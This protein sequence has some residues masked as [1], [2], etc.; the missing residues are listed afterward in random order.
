MSSEQHMFPSCMWRPKFPFH[1]FCH[2]S[3]SNATRTQSN[4]DML[5]CRCEM[6]CILIHV[7]VSCCIRSSVGR[8]WQCLSLQ[9]SGKLWW[10]LW[11]QLHCMQGAQ[12]GDYGR[13]SPDNVSDPDMAHE[14]VQNNVF[15]FCSLCK[16]NSEAAAG[17]VDVQ[18]TEIWTATA[19][20][21]EAPVTECRQC[22]KILSLVSRSQCYALY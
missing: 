4:R 19:N 9:V 22:C 2:V 10:I 7:F 13:Q 8:W 16:S 14:L 21:A 11:V 1:H 3:S 17:Y 18:V 12:T 5:K 20:S 15:T 6:Y